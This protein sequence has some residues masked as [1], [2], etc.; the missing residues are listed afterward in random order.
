[1][2]FNAEKVQKAFGYILGAG[3]VLG[4]A[5]IPVVSFEISAGI[6]LCVFLLWGAVHFMTS[7]EQ[8][9]GDKKSGTGGNGP[10]NGPKGPGSN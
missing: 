10:K 4:V 7:R 9:Q 8:K 2:N 1:M 5:V 3:V 6:V